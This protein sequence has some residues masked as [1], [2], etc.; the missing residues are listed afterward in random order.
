MTT[1]QTYDPQ[2]RAGVLPARVALGTMHG[3]ERAL[4]PAFDRL[5]V[6]LIV[7]DG[8]NTDRFGTFSAEIPRA[9]SMEDAARAK[10]EAAM[11]A[12]GLP[13]GLASEGAYGPHPAVPF[14]AAGLEI[15]MWR[16]AERGHEIIERL[17]DDR[18]AYD[19]AEVADIDQVAPVLT[20]MGFPE[21]AM[22][23]RPA[24]D[25]CGS[26]VKG[27]TGMSELATAIAAACKASPVG[28]AVVQ[29]DMRAHMNPQRMATIAKLGLRLADRLACRCDACGAPGWGRLRTVPGL[30][31]DWCGGPSLLIA[32]EVHGCTACGTTRP[33]PRPDGKTTADPGECPACNP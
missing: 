30:P 21:T 24:G 4:A 9:G 33:V 7:P 31:C 17:G 25:P 32:H 19:L 8:L 15:L 10:I 6:R 27:L 26:V 29:T 3:K 18:P 5:S 11:A 2:N 12:T 13:V 20:R 14:M 23:V 28:K 16:D 1:G 22:I